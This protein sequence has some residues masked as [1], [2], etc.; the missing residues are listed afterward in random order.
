[1]RQS[2][3]SCVKVLN[4]ARHI[5]RHLLWIWWNPPCKAH[6]VRVTL[7]IPEC[8]PPSPLP[9]SHLS[10]HVLFR[11]EYEVSGVRKSSTASSLDMWQCDC[12]SSS[13]FSSCR[14]LSANT[15][16][17]PKKHGL[18][19]IPQ[20]KFDPVISFRFQHQGSGFPERSTEC[21]GTWR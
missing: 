21:E 4:L 2:L 3:R 12:C 19:F 14:V 16:D 17:N 8:A 5:Y 1:M 11:N 18:L 7:I 13:D 15:G 10:L 6:V 20:C 9:P